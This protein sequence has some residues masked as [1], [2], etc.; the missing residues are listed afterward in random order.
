MKRDHP[1]N[2]RFH[3][4]TILAH[5]ESLSFRHLTGS[6]TLC[7][8]LSDLQPEGLSCR[9]S[10]QTDIPL[11]SPRASMPTDALLQSPARRARPWTPP[12]TPPKAA[13]TVEAMLVT[14]PRGP[15]YV[16]PAAL[17]SSS[18]L[19]LPTAASEPAYVK[20]LPFSLGWPAG[21][22][23]LLGKPPG[24]STPPRTSKETDTATAVHLAFLRPPHLAP[25]AFWPPE[26]ELSPRSIVTRAGNGFNDWVSQAF[27]WTEIMVI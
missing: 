16:L 5:Q 19:L 9:M 12:R 1:L 15:R 2:L 6:Y 27:A 10:S 3:E 21:W 26:S 11:A 22:P 14:P 25:G 23:A 20:V 18:P 8:F 13:A 24:L 4:S 7:S 17:Q